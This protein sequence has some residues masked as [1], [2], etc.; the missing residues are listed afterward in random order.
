MLPDFNLFG[1]GENLLIQADPFKTS[2][3]QFLKRFYLFIFRERGKEE[4]REGEKHQCMV[5]SHKFLTGDLACNP[6][7]YPV[8]ELNWLPFGP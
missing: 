5:A 2:C 3:F 4:E 6:G 1:V 7:M 8:W